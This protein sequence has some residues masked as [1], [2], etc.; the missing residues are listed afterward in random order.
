MSERSTKME[1]GDREGKVVMRFVQSGGDDGDG[2]LEFLLDPQQASEKAEAIAR[3]CYKARF[4]V[5]T[6]PKSQN[7]LAR[8]LREMLV[9]RIS[10]M[11]RSLQEQHKPRILIAQRVVD[12][13]LARA[14]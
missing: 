12:E 5:D 11:I 10:H 14:L 8:H 2:V 3:A 1:I 6:T 13:V 7:A 4:G 9:T